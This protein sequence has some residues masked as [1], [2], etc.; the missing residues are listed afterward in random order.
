MLQT[1][2]IGGAGLLGMYFGGG[3]MYSIVGGMLGGMAIC[4]VDTN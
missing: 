1:L 4:G 2:G 3:L